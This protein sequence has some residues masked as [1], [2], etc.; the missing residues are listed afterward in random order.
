[1][2]WKWRNSLS[3]FVD[4][5][6]VA[7]TK[8][9][10]A[11]INFHWFLFFFAILFCSF[12]FFDSTNR[13][14]WF[15]P[16]ILEIDALWHNVHYLLYTIVP[17]QNSTNCVDFSFQFFVGNTSQ[18]IPI[19]PCSLKFNHLIYSNTFICG[20]NTVNPRSPTNYWFFYHFLLRSGLDSL[21]LYVFLLCNVM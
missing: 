20:T 10:F 11:T 13:F 18:Y 15:L 2:Q 16:K 21:K 4:R 19:L 17:W 3:Q 8:T 12:R 7:K 6:Y 14:L 1:M 9:G 5:K